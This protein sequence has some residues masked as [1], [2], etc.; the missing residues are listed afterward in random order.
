MENV[1]LSERERS[2]GEIAQAVRQEVEKIPGADIKVT[3]SSMTSMG[4]SSSGN[5]IEIQVRGEDL[6]QLSALADEIVG[7][8]EKVEGTQEVESNLE[9]GA[10]EVTLV[11]DRSKLSAYGLTPTGVANS[12]QASVMGTVAIPVSYRG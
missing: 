4:G 1:A 8:V 11:V 10:P 2:T 6:D 3:V 9:G 7:V 5:P 12:V